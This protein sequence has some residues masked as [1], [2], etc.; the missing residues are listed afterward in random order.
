M[1]ALLLKDYY[2]VLKNIKII[3]LVSAVLITAF[4][5]L[6]GIVTGQTD[7]MFFISLGMS[8][9]WGL[10][11]VILT[12]VTFQFDENSGW[13]QYALTTPVS[14][15]EYLNSKYLFLLLTSIGCSL[16][17]MA[18]SAITSL[19]LGE[20]NWK[21]YLLLIPAFAVT[22]ILFSM[23][24][25]SWMI[26]LFIRFRCQKAVTVMFGVLAGWF[27]VSISL[28]LLSAMLTHSDAY[29]ELSGQRIA[30]IFLLLF[31]G[32]TIG[33]IFQSYRWIETKEV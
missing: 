3:T 13:M 20:I 9:F 17:G 7:A 23:I 2:A 24:L 18:V 15:K 12:R 5:S 1:K 29:S 26:P 11:A 19:I 33:M 22:G 16:C 8:L 14:R 6:T 10:F 25:G 4:L 32:S 21:I 27:A 31:A 30:E 28:L